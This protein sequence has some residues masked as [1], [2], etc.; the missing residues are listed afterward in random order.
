MKYCLPLAGI[1]VSATLVCAQTPP[2]A[3]K[4]Q[5][6]DKPA[7]PSAP[8]PAVAVAPETVIL[9]I[10][11]EKVTL[12][13]FEQIIA[14]L[15]DQQRAQLQAPG[16]KRKLAESLA[17]LKALA[18]EGRA[19]KLDQSPK[20]QTQIRLQTEQIIAQNMFQ[21][22]AS[23]A[24]PDEAALHTYYDAHKN[25]WE[26]VSA[27]HILIR[28]QGSTVPI[29]AG[30]KD[31]T[32]AEA[33]AKAQEIR[34]RIVGGAKFDDE[35]KIHSDDV[36]NAPQGGDLGSFTKGRMVPAFEQVAF[37]SEVGKIS[38]PV[39]T[40]FGYHLI[41]VTAHANKTFEQVRPEIEAKMKPELGQKALADLKA[42]KNI[43]FDETYFGK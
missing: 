36:G 43:V 8:K 18:Q 35:A 27:K 22:L 32:D 21:E 10:G 39:K 42:K 41:M 5:A 2:P 17:E 14:T 16:G 12:A 38:E 34:A 11:D 31:M 4:P 26:E 25:E 1:L 40:Q 29:R 6:A 7:V 15:P 30:M 24:K 13:Q 19:H 33:L 3:P 28:F 37:A 9:T 23:T 20:I